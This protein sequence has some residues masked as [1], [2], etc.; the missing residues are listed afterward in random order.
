MPLFISEEEFRQCS[1]DA[2]LVA[3][4]AD[5]FIRELFGQIETVKAEADA[6]SITL[7]Q[8]CS[9]IEQKYM[10]ISAEYSS[11][12]SQ[13]SEL[14]SSLEQRTSELAQLQ[15][16]KQ[17]LLLQSI[18]KDGETE[19]LK[20]EAS[21]FHKSK[22]QLM[23]LLEQKD[24]EVSEKNATIKSYLDKIVNLT[25]N[26]A[27]KDGRVGELESELGRTQATSARLMQE[28]ELLERHNIWLNEE[29]TSKVN[30]LIQLRRANGE[31]EAEMSSKL[32]EVEKKYKES[33]SSLTLHKDIARELE[34][35]LASMETEL[36]STKDA[37]AAAEGRFSAEIST[38]TKLVDLYKESSEEWSKKAG[39][40]DGVI[41]ALETHLNQVESEYKDKLEKEVSA[42][43]KVE[44][45]STD[46]KDK[47]QTVE[48]ELSNSRK[49]NE[50]NHLPL[51]SFTVETRWAKSVDAD[52]MV[53]DDRAIVPR[54]P[55]GVSG[56]ALA[57]SLLRDGWTL[58]QM[59][60][61]YQEAVDALRHEQLGRKQSQDILER[62]LYE[63]EKKAGAIMDEREEH[64]KLIE[65]Y[66]ALDEKLQHALSEHSALERTI[67]DLKASL[68]S[69]ERD[70][71]VAQKE[72]V[73]LQKQVTVLL[74]ECRDVQLRCGSV[75]RYSGSVARYNDDELVS[76]PIVPLHDQ[77]N[78]EKIISE[79][80]LT[81]KDINGLVEQN[82]Q[83][84]SLVRHLSDQIE[85]KETEWK[86]KNEK[87]FQLLTDETT[88]KV[89]A[90][91]L[92]AEE[93]SQMVESLHSS[94]AMYKKLYEEEH[95][96]R[97]NSTHTQV[98]VPE[99]QS[100]EV[101]VSQERS[102]DPQRKAQ[103][104]AL[105]RL[106]NI[107]DELAKSRNDIILL[108]SERD[109][110]AM[111]V[112][113][114]QEKLARFMKEFDH[115]REEQHKVIAR[116][117]EFSQLIVDYQKK[118]RE[119]AESFDSANEHSR[120][121]TMEV[122]ILK[123][124]KEILLDSEKRASDEVRSLTERV[125]RLQ[126]SLDTIHSTEEVREEVRVIER[127]K[128]E[129][130]I[131]KLEREWAEAKE[132]LQEERDAVRNLTLERESSMK[133]GFK[134]VED[135][136][137]ELATA[138]QSVAA[139]ESR[140]AVAEARCSD[141]ERIMK[142]ARTKDSDGSD[143]GLSSSNE[144]LVLSND[145]HGVTEICPATFRHSVFQDLWRWAPW[146]YSS[147][148]G[149]GGILANFRDEI[150]NLRRDAQASKDH[151]LQ[152]KSIA[153]VNEEALKQM[154]LAHEN[155]RNE[156]DDVKRS[157]ES[158]IHSLRERFIELES[159]C[160][161]KTE[162][163]IS[164]TA[165]KEEALAGSL[166]E[167][168]SL[169]D[170]C[171][172]KM[173]QIVVLESQI[174]A[175]KDD[176]ESEHQ[177]WR[178]TQDNYERQVILQSETIQE[179]TKTSQALSSAQIETSELRKVVDQLKTEN[180]HL[181]SKWET[182][183]SAI[184]VYKN[185]ADKKYTEV[186]ELN[187]ILHSRL[188]ALHIKIAEKERGIASGSGPQ[189][190]ADNDGLQ[191]V[192]NYLRRSKEIAETEISLL[193]QEK[194]RLQSQ[195]EV[196]LKS[197]EAAQTSFQ[198]ERAKSRASL[199]TEEEFKSLQLQVRELTLLRE[200]NVQ[201]REENRH[202]FE[203]CQ[204]LREAL[205][206]VRIEIENL[207]RLLR[208]RDAELEACRKEIETLKMEK[209]NLEEKIGELVEKSKA[210][211]IDEYNQLKDSLQQTQD[212]L[213]GKDSELDEVKKLLLDK[214]NT[215]LNL[216]KLFSERQDAASLLDRD[217]ARIRTE[218]NERES[219]I[220][221]MSKN[222]TTLKSDLDKANE[223]AKRL[224]AQ[225]RRTSTNLQKEKEELT[226]EMQSLSKQLDE[227][228][229]QTK[230]NTGDPAHEQALR[231]KDTR[232]HILE[233]T[234]ERHREDLK[235]EKEDHLK[236]KER[237]MKIKKMI[238]ESHGNVAQ[239]RSRFM[240]ELNKHRQALKALQDEVD[241]LKNSGGDQS[242]S[243]QNFTST[244]LEDFASA[245]F[246]AVDNFDQAAQPASGD[247]DST[248]SDAPLADINTSSSTPSASNVPVT[249]SSEEKEKRLTLSK[250][251]VKFGRKLVRPSI[252]KTKEPQGDVE[253]SEA[254][255]PNTAQNTESQVNETNVQTSAA[256]GRKRPSASSSSDLQEETL[257]TPKET[258][259]DVPTPVL[260]K[261][262]PSETEQEGGGEEQPSDASKLSEVV[263]A[264]DE[265]LD[266]VS[267]NKD[268]PVDAERDAAEKDEEYETAGEQQME[269][270]KAD[271]QTQA[272]LPLSDTGDVAVDENS[273][274][275]SET[276]LSDDQM[277]E[278]TEQD[279]QCIVTEPGDREEGELFGDFA[280]NDGESNISN[281]MGPT[282]IGEFQAEQSEEQENSLEAGEID[283]EDTATDKSTKVTT[284]G[285]DHI[286]G[287]EQ[288]PE[289]SPN[290]ANT[291]DA[292]TSAAGGGGNV[293]S[294][295][296]V[297]GGPA[298]SP[299]AG[300]KPA[301][302][303]N[304][305]STTINLQ[306]RARLRSQVRHANM[307][308]ASSS[309]TLS[310]GRG[311]TIR[312]RGVRG[313]RAGR[314]QSPG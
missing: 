205:Q 29:L 52:E 300:V 221:D 58:A 218:L 217:I 252:T 104:Q 39:E 234:L 178:T 65:A 133:N 72:I 311:R 176:L 2:G 20:M 271:D 107:E 224:A 61:K 302:P 305:S 277:R 55:A 269:E 116:N 193:K 212:Y 85:E 220:A 250:G 96:H 154:E 114:S 125:H 265:S 279:I 303:L 4:K 312:G 6:T 99:Q 112:Q 151:M 53:V 195:L 150:E 204:K 215:I 272:G 267:V 103:E 159:V 165:E 32:E 148:H 98:A 90:V 174:F 30:S 110:I 201:L 105:E 144:N 180:K 266:D 95:K 233:K 42:R 295:V 158:E 276:A 238:G 135:L 113:F 109:K 9:L 131:N 226:K 183:S 237:C 256:V 284:E 16:E 1:G 257:V 80:L 255:E 309:P 84:R 160:K 168:A 260:K 187:K 231:E 79:R 130:Y 282:G 122:S 177:R 153:Q 26:A 141:L 166:S 155:Y 264:I 289:S 236:E 222:E 290:A 288:V 209:T 81:F 46:L 94:V 108:R 100:R 121:L 74:K 123:H 142:S 242:E 262:K 310:R 172:A 86:N 36:L 228:K 40:L 285:G 82:V 120:K 88:S 301:S 50:L 283:D 246:Q 240:G 143:G 196:S 63:I 12:Q 314:G 185:E 244:I 162:E 128:Q 49:D 232:M 66:S 313:G 28:K 208:E 136:S 170:D 43:K 101:V 156:A 57:A 134:Q 24:L 213:R 129:D 60:A 203:E 216:E 306:E 48:A 192:V 211:D 64:E 17:Q 87:Q 18:E 67:Q 140:A 47:L 308:G 254:D 190:L 132:Q 229:Q 259:T 56:T 198:S 253:M 145:G 92:R 5:A 227:A 167:I 184:E 91:L 23:E 119:S 89:N 37:A 10:S 126:A 202:N 207:E 200:S 291:E 7:E 171:S 157:L 258:I 298:M 281:E 286:E 44:K 70:S 19:R 189:S 71:A 251:S 51:S 164:A 41:K 181:K 249:R 194:L 191:T 235:K 230:R 76:G 146:R 270:P 225:A 175:L 106:K 280:D 199:F 210:V 287:T 62:V 278:Q 68:K 239:Q 45:E 152:Y 22:R 115:Q 197:A 292:S 247:L 27:S 304:S 3:E 299:E 186:D 117:V 38:V 35:K 102:H 263:V 77:S 296:V 138:L 248:V 149:H 182:E 97:S 241:K 139:A 118:L 206:N 83:L 137:K 275:P 54:I 161:L 297:Q 173:S 243:A 261:S 21:E 8:N 34:E 214:E 124:E 273:D 268:E 147:R 78:S 219:K 11:I 188:E 179:L 59:Y 33:S 245:Y 111:E 75:A 93:Q 294:S 274:K 31:L 169:K 25:G 15:S 127:R 293:G 13:H 163:V 73:D 69:Q 14:N 223:K 307:S